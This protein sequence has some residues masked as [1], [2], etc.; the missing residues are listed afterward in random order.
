LGSQGTQIL[1]KIFSIS[2]KNPDTFRGN[3]FQTS[4]VRTT[5]RSEQNMKIGTGSVQRI[6]NYGGLKFPIGPHY[7]RNLRASSEDFRTRSALRAFVRLSSVVCGTGR[8]A[9]LRGVQ[10]ID[11]AHSPERAIRHPCDNTPI[12]DRPL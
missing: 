10:A 4:G 9:L 7:E 2:G 3:F 5:P 12:S 6:R 11:A 1:T 8:I